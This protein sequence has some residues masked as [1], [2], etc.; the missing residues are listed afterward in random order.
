MTLLLASDRLVVVDSTW[1]RS[2]VYSRARVPGA[3]TTAVLQHNRTKV[4]IPL[5]WTQVVQEVAATHEDMSPFRKALEQQAEMTRSD[6]TPCRYLTTDL[7][8]VLCDMH[9][10]AARPFSGGKPFLF[11]SAYTGWMQL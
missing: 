2:S 9:D 7:L 4:A 3:Y 8:R 11:P 10:K 5:S 1:L 6:R